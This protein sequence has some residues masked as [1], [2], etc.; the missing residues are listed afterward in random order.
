VAVSQTPHPAPLN[1]LLPAAAALLALFGLFLVGLQRDSLWFDEAY[2]LYVV[3]DAGRPP[4]GLTDS[5]RFVVGSL[6]AALERARADV[7]PPLYFVLMDGWILLAG[8]SALAARLPSAWAA[9]VGLAAV[10]ALGRRLGGARA[11]LIALVVLGT[12]SMTVYYSRE[13]RMYTLLLALATLATLAYLRWSAQPDRRRTLL[14]GALLA[15]LAYVHYAGI[16]IA[17]THALHRLLLHPRRAWILIWPGG[18]AL[19]FYAPWLP[20]LIEQWQAHGGPAAPPFTDVGVALAALVFFLTG[21]YWALYALPLLFGLA[22]AQREARWL[23]ALWL[24]LTPAALLLL[25]G[26][27]PAVFQVRYVV[28]ILPAGALLIALGVRQMRL[29]GALSRSMG[30]GV[31]LALLTA[32]LYTQLTVYPFVWPPKS[33][34]QEA[35]RLV[36]EARHP[37]EP[38]ISAIPAHSPAAYYDR[39]Y[40]YRGGLALDLGWRWQEADAMRTYVQLFDRAESVWLVMPSTY[41]SAWDAAR[42]LL[43]DRTVGYRDSVMDML[44]YRFDR[45]PSSDLGFRLGDLLVYQGGIRHEL[46]ARPGE[47]FC[48]TLELMALAAVPPGYAVD[49]YLTQGYNTL[50]AGTTLDLGTYDAGEAIPLAP[51]LALAADHP[52]GPH[53][54]R[55]RV[56]RPDTGAALPLLERGEVYWGDVLMLALVHV[57]E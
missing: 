54:L 4:D 14:Y 27:I 56:Y 37:L 22:A 19:A 12:A 43:V 15:L 42:A 28:A 1:R 44:F 40:G 17:L 2:T 10:Y 53:H 32:L 21:G 6:R 49:V 25:N 48:F 8:E 26:L 9:L 55:L 36:A 24:L 35:A 13:A 33:R 51:C 20:A 23:L 52:A 31:G 46:Y 16:L 38:L 57:G 39:M 11:G 29:P 47:P 30:Q 7:H 34:W 45:G 3:H 5:L 18:L 50:R 41:A